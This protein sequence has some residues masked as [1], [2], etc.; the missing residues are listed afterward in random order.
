MTLCFHKGVFMMNEVILQHYKDQPQIKKKFY[1]TLPLFTRIDELM[2]E[3]EHVLVAIDG[4]SA[5]GKTTLAELLKEVYDCNIV[6]I[7][8]FFLRPQQRSSE[9]LDEPG[10]NI[11]YERLT[12]EVLDKLKANESFSYRPFNCK[13]GDFDEPISL[14][15]KKLTI[16][17][18]SYSHHPVLAKNYDLKIFLSIPE[19]VQLGRILKRNGDL[20]YEQFKNKWIPMEKK[21]AEAFDIR[22][23]SDLQFDYLD[24]L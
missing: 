3:Q 9:H 22:E 4:D 7:D 2:S 13:R 1:E 19:A 14:S 18:G 17:E 11:D 20:M 21:Y 8:H 5:A 15:A 10:G 12:R 24:Y 23:N 6:H 16:I